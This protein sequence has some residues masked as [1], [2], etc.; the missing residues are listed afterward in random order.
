MSDESILKMMNLR[1]EKYTP[2][3][4]EWSKTKESKKI[5]AK[6]TFRSLSGSF[7]STQIKKG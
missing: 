4:V 7:L 2:F 5:G 6:K 1:I 3:Y